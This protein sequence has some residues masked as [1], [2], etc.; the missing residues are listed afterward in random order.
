MKKQYISITAILLGLC[1]TAGTIA[2]QSEDKPASGKEVV[3]ITKTV[4]DDG[5]E[6]MVKKVYKDG[7]LSD[8]ELDQLIQAETG[9]EVDVN[10]WKSDK[11]EEIE[12]TID[13]TERMAFVAEEEIDQILK[14][15]KLTKEDMQQIDI[16]VDSEIVNGK[17]V[18]KEIITIVDKTGKQYELERKKEITAGDSPTVIMKHEH[19]PKLGVMVE[20]TPLGHVVV[21]GI[22]PGSP[23]EKAGLQKGDHITAIGHTPVSNMDELLAALSAVGDATSVSYTRDGEAAIAAVTFSDFEYEGAAKKKI[24]KRMIIKED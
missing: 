14:D 3:I 8:E 9:A 17:E 5:N 22:V 7:E 13:D 18:I 23:A 10:I 19:K 1:L 24:R 20:E 15:L 6:K 11:G 4:D 2:G 21:D 16:N 12:I